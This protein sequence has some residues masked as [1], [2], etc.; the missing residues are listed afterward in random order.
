L[1]V[2]WLMFS[3]NTEILLYPLNVNRGKFI[4]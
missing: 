2:L 1:M 3:L 4:H